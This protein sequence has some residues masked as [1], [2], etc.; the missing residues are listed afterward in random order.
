ME[1]RYDIAHFSFVI[2]V[3]VGYTFAE[4]QDQGIFFVQ[5]VTRCPSNLY[6]LSEFESMSN[7]DFRHDDSGC[8]RYGVVAKDGEG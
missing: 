8:T 1:G 2:Y 6:R 4:F 5:M 3:Y 7:T